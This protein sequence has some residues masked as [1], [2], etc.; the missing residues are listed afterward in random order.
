MPERYQLTLSDEEVQ[1][2]ESIRDHDPKPHRREKAAA[3][4]KVHAGESIRQVAQH[5]LLK[6]RRPHTVGRWLANFRQRG[7]AGLD[8]AAGRGR[9][10]RFF[11]PQPPRSSPAT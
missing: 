4:L 6:S 9:H 7:E 3:I 2:L 10:R 5:G 1:R 11:P 8:V